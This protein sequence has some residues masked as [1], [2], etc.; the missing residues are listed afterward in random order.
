MQ[1]LA[2][3]V[4]DWWRGQRVFYDIMLLRKV[5]K[6]AATLHHGCSMQPLAKFKCIQLSNIQLLRLT[7]N[8]F[9]FLFVCLFFHRLFDSSHLKLLTHGLSKILSKYIRGLSRFALYKPSFAYL[10][11]KLLESCFDNCW[12]FHR[13][14]CNLFVRSDCLSHFLT[15]KCKKQLYIFT[16][17]NAVVWHF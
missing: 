15:H 3:L 16:S 14:F 1:C 5:R 12:S 4:S 17:V 8:L 9:V 6:T 11:R 7:D 10:W 2:V 13:R